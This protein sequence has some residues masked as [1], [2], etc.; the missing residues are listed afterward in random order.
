MS[1][2]PGFDHDIFISYAI[3]DDAK[4][5]GVE[6]GWVSAFV[7]TLEISL[8]TAIGRLGRLE[9]WWDRTHLSENQPLDKQIQQ[10][11]ERTACLVV[12]LSP[13][14]LESPWCPKELQTFR[15]A[16]AAQVRADSRIFVVDLGSVTEQQ[17]RQ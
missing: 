11:L 10:A 16:I 1:Y 6:S 8:S 14:F 7:K 13:G 15:G 12:I 2:V 17:R 5:S 9:P 3:V 4:R